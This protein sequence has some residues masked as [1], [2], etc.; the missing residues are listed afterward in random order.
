MAKDD[1][2]S[3]P[4]VVW[5]IPRGSGESQTPPERS[6]AEEWQR[7]GQELRRT[8]LTG[9][10]FL[11]GLS[12]PLNLPEPSAGEPVA[13]PQQRRKAGAKPKYDWDAIQ[14]YCHQLFYTNGFPENVSAF[15]RDEIIPWCG[16]QYG[17]DGTPDMETL[18][19]L[20]TRWIAAWV[21]SLPLK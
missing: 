13:S 11:R 7:R 6:L 8:L 20:V 21:R 10:A 12:T 18:R 4:V 15:C 19:P 5:E 16:Q 3:T 1:D 9:A 14:A 17:E 2:K